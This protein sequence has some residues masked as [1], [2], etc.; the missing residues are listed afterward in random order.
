MIGGQQP[1]PLEGMAVKRGS[2]AL[3]IVGLL[4]FGGLVFGGSA[5]AAPS[6]MGTTAS[7]SSANSFATSFSANQTTTNSSKK[8]DHD[9]V[10]CNPAKIDKEG[11]KCKVTMR[12][13]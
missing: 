4:A 8:H 3:P 13:L 12:G 2:A 1:I 5:V 7:S 11:G 9:E 10:E 6:Q